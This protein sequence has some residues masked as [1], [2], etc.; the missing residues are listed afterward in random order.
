MHLSET[1]RWP[2]DNGAQITEVEWDCAV[3]FLLHR[4][5]MEMW[6]EIGQKMAEKGARWYVGEA[7]TIGRTVRSLLGTGGFHWGA[8]CIQANWFKLLED[9][10]RRIYLAQVRIVD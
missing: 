6:L 3:S 1:S 9:C 7:Q 2:K 8:V 5:D 4:M 10:V